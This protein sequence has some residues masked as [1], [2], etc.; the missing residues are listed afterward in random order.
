MNDAERRWRGER[1]GSGDIQVRIKMGSLA[2]SLL[3]AWIAVS[4]VLLLKSIVV[5]KFWAWFLEPWLSGAP[6]MSYVEALGVTLIWWAVSSPN[7]EFGPEDEVDFGRAAMAF[8]M[9]VIVFLF[10]LAVKSWLY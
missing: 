3:A 4:I 1:R 2:G 5:W 10:G 6:S 8:S 7:L 9:P